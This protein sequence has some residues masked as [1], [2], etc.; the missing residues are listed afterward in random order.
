MALTTQ[1]SVDAN[2][3]LEVVQSREVTILSGENLAAMSVLGKITASGK[4]ILSDDGAGDGSEVPDAILMEAVDATGGDKVGLALFSGR[5][6]ERKL[7]LGGAHT[8]D[9]IREGL[10]QK[11]ILLFDSVPK[12]AS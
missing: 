4:Y 11:D 8:A 10:R 7:V 12:E 5:A 9:S 1:N 2:D 6:L 3:F